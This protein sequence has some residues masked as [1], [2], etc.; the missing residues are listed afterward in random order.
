IAKGKDDKGLRV[1]L[2]KDLNV[3]IEQPLYEANR[4]A[5]VNL[6]DYVKS[7]I[8]QNPRSDTR[9]RLNRLL[10]EAAYPGEIRKSRGGVYP[11]R[12]IYIPSLH[13]HEEA[14]NGYTADAARR[15]QHD[16]RF[17]NEPKQIRPGEGI[18]V[19]PDGRVQVF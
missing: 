6:S 15:Y 18:N 5:Q 3:L 16:M 11:D 13:D 10:L 8:A 2:A 7:F 17:P 14:I 19:T 9:I 1:N 12:E 4:F